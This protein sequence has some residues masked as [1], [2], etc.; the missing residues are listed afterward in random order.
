VLVLG[1]SHAK[2]VVLAVLCQH[3]ASVRAVRHL[4]PPTDF[5]RPPDLA[6]FWEATFAN[7]ASLVVLGNHPLAY[8]TDWPGA[9]RRL[10]PRRRK[11]SDYGAVVLGQTNRYEPRHANTNFFVAMVGYQRRHPDLS[12]DVERNPGPSLPDL[13]SLYGGPIVALPMF[14]GPGAA[15]AE[16]ATAEARRIRLKHNRSNVR[17]LHTRRHIL[18]TGTEC[19]STG[20]RASVGTCAASPGAHRCTGPSGGDADL[21]AWDLVEALHGAIQ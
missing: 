8:S 18:E 12:I 13:A 1:N 16:A 7:G 17:V 3:S 15:W 9:V 11:L 20:G 4:G 5:M 21:V 19:G 10:D 14:S 6:A 2:Q